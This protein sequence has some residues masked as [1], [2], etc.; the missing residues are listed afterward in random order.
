MQKSLLGDDREK[1]VLPLGLE[2]LG[3]WARSVST[4]IKDSQDHSGRA[5]LITANAGEKNR[6]VAGTRSGFCYTRTQLVTV[7]LITG[8]ASTQ[9]EHTIQLSH[10]SADRKRREKK[11]VTPPDT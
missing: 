2:N 4:N 1:K 5:E 7:F 9:E 8:L 10:A 11:G 3:F 6:P